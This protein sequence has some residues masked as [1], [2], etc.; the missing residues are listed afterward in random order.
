M[1]SCVMEPAGTGWNRPMERSTNGPARANA[2]IDVQPG[3]SGDV[4]GAGGPAPEPPLPAA[5][6]LATVGEKAVSHELLLQM[7]GRTEDGHAQ[8]R[9]TLPGLRRRVDDIPSAEARARYLTDVPAH[10]R[11]LSLAREWLG[12][13]ALREA[14][15]I[16]APAPISTR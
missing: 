4:E 14:G 8:L 6:I 16:D 3:P 10:A 12:E 7:T 2:Q 11:L 5:E 13:E 1:R 15:L 9:E